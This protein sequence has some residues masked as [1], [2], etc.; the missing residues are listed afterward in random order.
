MKVAIVSD[1]HGNIEAFRAVIVQ[2]HKLKCESM[3]V[4]GDILGYYYHPRE[5]FEEIDLWN[6]HIIAGNHERIFLKYLENNLEYNQLINYNYGSSFSQAALNFNMELIHKIEKLDTE[7][8]ITID[9]LKILL[10]H[11]SPMNMD[12]Y[13][14]PDVSI[15][16]LDAVKAYNYDV[17]LM[18]H[19]HYPCVFNSEGKLIINPGSVGQSRVYGG[20]ANWGILNTSNK[21]Y[22][23]QATMYNV[24]NVE[25]EVMEFDPE[26]EFLLSVLRRSN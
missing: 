5:I 12:Q 26:N 15:E 2:A 10:T 17:I 7:K 11:G 14:Y 25:K 8:S 4:L 22:S 20:V 9:G 19:T 16:L 1:I 6:H 24:A 13:I 23:P 18:G 3:L 21:S